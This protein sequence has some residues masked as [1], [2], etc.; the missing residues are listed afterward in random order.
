MLG[1]YSQWR[2]EGDHSKNDCHNIRHH[3]KLKSRHFLHH[4]H[5][6]V[7]S[8]SRENQRFARWFLMTIIANNT[9]LK[10]REHM[11]SGYWV[12]NL[13]EVEIANQQEMMQKLQD[14]AHN[15]LVICQNCRRNWNE[16]Q[17]LKK[18][19]LDSHQNS[20]EKHQD[21]KRQKQFWIYCRQDLFHWPSRL[22]KAK[23]HESNGKIAG[24]S[25]GDK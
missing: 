8:V 7:W 2:A 22:W 10:V 11:K 21:W 1:E 3:S 16:W 9:N 13:S 20:A 23:G 6:N 14:G 19:Q 25:K 18:P 4:H 12:Q 24:R 17:K 5:V 15:R